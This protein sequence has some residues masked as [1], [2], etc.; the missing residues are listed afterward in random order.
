MAGIAGVPPQHVCVVDK[1]VIADES[2]LMFATDHHLRI[3]TNDRYRDWRI[4]FPRAAEKGALV[5]GTWRQGAVIWR[6][7]L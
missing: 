7:A 3:V 1:G 2:I 5:G 4:R 6:G